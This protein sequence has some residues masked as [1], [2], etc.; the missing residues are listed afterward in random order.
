[1]GLEV[2]LADADN[3]F[4]RDRGLLVQ[5]RRGRLTIPTLDRVEDVVRHL[6]ATWNAPVGF[7]AVL[8]PTAETVSNEVRARQ[9]QIVREAD[10]ADVRMALLVVGDGLHAKL[11][12]T[13]ARALMIATP[14]MKCV[15]DVDGAARWV[16]THRS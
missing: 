4:T 10:R 3:V 1:M 5:V 8:E 14:R 11:S 2:V 16:A 7:V 6:H 13:I 12:R 15:G 9:R